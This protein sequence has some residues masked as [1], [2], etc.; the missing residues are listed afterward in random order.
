M[1]RSLDNIRYEIY[2]HDLVLVFSNQFKRIQDQVIIQQNGNFT[3]AE[4]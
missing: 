4:V 1:L 2:V 3:Q